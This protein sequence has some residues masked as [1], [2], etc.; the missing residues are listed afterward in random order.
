MPSRDRKKSAKSEPVTPTGKNILLYP[1][2]PLQAPWKRASGHQMTSIGQATSCLHLCATTHSLLQ[3]GTNPPR[4][5]TSLRRRHR[6]VKT[7]RRR[8]NESSLTAYPQ[9]LLHVDSPQVGFFNF[10]QI[11][12]GLIEQSGRILV[13][14]VK[15]ALQWEVIGLQTA[16][17]GKVLKSKGFQMA[18][19]VLIIINVSLWSNKSLCCPCVTCVE[20][21]SCGAPEYKHL[22]R[23]Q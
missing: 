17:A 7:S 10:C 6:E 14:A 18:C 12:N 16:P 19:L 2:L 4:S 3:T 21:K 5:S 8:A 23:M 13:Q 9:I 22:G 11:V 15:I 20:G 1:S